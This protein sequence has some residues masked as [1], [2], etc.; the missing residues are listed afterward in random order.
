[1]DMALK[2][3]YDKVKSS[4]DVR[5]SKFRK[6][7]RHDLG[8]FFCPFLRLNVGAKLWVSFKLCFKTKIREIYYKGLDFQINFSAQQKAKKLGKI[9][10]A[11]SDKKFKSTSVHKKGNKFGLNRG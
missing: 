2:H 6:I 3:F 10:Y 9:S 7:D 8:L 5:K 1:M 4:Y 11:V